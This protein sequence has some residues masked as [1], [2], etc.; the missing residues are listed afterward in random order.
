MFFQYFQNFYIENNNNNTV[1]NNNNNITDHL[2]KP[3]IIR[4]DKDESLHSERSSERAILMP[5]EVENQSGNMDKIDSISQSI[6]NT[7]RYKQQE[8]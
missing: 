2:N 6:D 1:V 3:K 7:S 8:R 4:N 5:A